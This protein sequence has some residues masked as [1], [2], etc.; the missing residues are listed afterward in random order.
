M[1]MKKSCRI[2][3]YASLCAGMAF[4]S[5]MAET[6]ADSTTL[7]FSPM[8]AFVISNNGPGMSLRSLVAIEQQTADGWKA[9]V[10]AGKFFNA[11]SVGRANFGSNSG[12]YAL[13][14]VGMNVTGAASGNGEHSLVPPQATQ[15]STSDCIELNTNSSISVGP[16]DGMSCQ[17]SGCDSNGPYP[18]GIY[19]FVITTCD[20]NQRIISPPFEKTWDMS[21][22][23]GKVK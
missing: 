16:W 13:S 19:R 4:V 7:K 20:G 1:F 12:K 11:T 2:L 15:S 18:N 22:M 5:G 9:T 17:E 8:T 3:L 21:Q 23:L 10:V 6:R 14:I